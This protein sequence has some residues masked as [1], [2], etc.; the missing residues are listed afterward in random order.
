M[1]G[2]TVVIPAG[3][4]L[5]AVNSTNGAELWRAARLDHPS[6]H[7]GVV[8]GRDGDN[9][10]ALDAATGR[11][12]WSAPGVPSYGEIWALGDGSVYVLS[13]GD[14]PGGPVVVAYDLHSGAERWR[15][16]PSALLFGEPMAGGKDV[17]FV[18]WEVVA[19]AVSS[20]TG[21]HGGRSGLNSWSRHG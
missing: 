6:G 20:P 3:E 5:V 12:L 10:T 15:F 19:G 17:M 7:D 16:I 21:R 9:V 4:Q 14:G 11:K 2:S 8:V 18:G 13:R 1:V